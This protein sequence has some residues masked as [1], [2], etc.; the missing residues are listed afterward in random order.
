MKTYSLT[1]VAAL[2]A[3]GLMFG[4]SA[5]ES[6]EKP[7][8]PVRVKT[9]ETHPATASVRY[10]ASIRPAAQVDVAFK[11]GGY[12]D[13]IAQVRD[14][15]GQS[16]YIQAG[17]IVHKGTVLARVRQSDYAARVNE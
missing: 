1:I 14:S 8:T 16:R 5:G 7:P 17:D 15:A 13:A 9:V 3:T 11:V 12:I 4:C 6:K 2:L 10:S